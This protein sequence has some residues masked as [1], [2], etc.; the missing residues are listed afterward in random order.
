MKLNGIDL[1]S[2][3]D[4]RNETSFILS[5]TTLSA[6]LMLDDQTLI[7]TAANDQEYRRYEGYKVA[8]VGFVNEDSTNIE[9]RVIKKLNDSTEAAINALETNFNTLQ[10]QT[11]AAQ[12][13]A[14]QAVTASTENA[15]II[16]EANQGIGELGVI[17]AE[18]QEAIGELGVMIATM[19][20]GEPSA[21]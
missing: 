11:Q 15:S 19:Q 18:T 6:A 13:T 9:L 2:Y 8:S 10:T 1:V 20:S 3:S 14:N 4:L 16:A 7:I 17:V 5:N 21:S 12:S